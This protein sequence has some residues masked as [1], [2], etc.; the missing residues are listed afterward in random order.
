[1]SRVFITGPDGL[2]GSNVIRELLSRNHEVTALVQRGRDPITLQGL[3]I[4]I[5]YGDVTNPEDLLKNS[6]GCEYMIHIA[7]ITDMWPILGEH[8]YKVNVEGTRNAINAALAHKVKR[9]IHVGSASCFGFGSKSSPGDEETPFKS[10]K[11][12]LDYIMSKKKAH[13]LVLDSIQNK[14]LPGIIICPTF[15]IGPHDSKPSSGALI[16]AIKNGSLPVLSPGGKNWVSVKAVSVALCNA[17]E[18]GRVGESYICGG[19]NLS[20]KEAIERISVAAGNS[21]YPRK[22]LPSFLIKTA[23]RISSFVAVV[24]GKP[25]RLSYQTAWIACEHH[26]FDSSKAIRELQL[27]FVSIEEASMDAISWFSKKGYL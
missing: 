18:N 23:G 3:P 13:E 15:M 16:I 20:Y 1:M 27:P 22:P 26:Y 7:A 4:D 12:G 19:E 2:L 25:P 11:Y 14:G 6:V 21:K 24:T 9:F 5:V 8:Y 10:Q 17:L